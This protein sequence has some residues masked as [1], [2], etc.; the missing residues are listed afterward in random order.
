MRIAK[1]L[2]ALSGGLIAIGCAMLAV[3]AVLAPNSSGQRSAFS[4]G[5]VLAGLVLIAVAFVCIIL[6]F[7]FRAAEIRAFERIAETLREKL[8]QWDYEIHVARLNDLGKVYDYALESLGA[9]VVD[10]NRMQAWVKRNPRIFQMVIPRGQSGIRGIYSLL[11]LNES[12]RR[13]MEDDLLNAQG[14]VPQHIATNSKLAKCFYIGA[15]A[16]NTKLAQGI[17]LQGLKSEIEIV[18]KDQ[19]VYTRP[20]TAAGMRICQK[21][22]FEPL[23]LAGLGKLYYVDLP[24][25]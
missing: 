25:P 24:I 9:G 11:P 21:W 3:S 13:L 4:S 18:A 23:R 17:A 7:V 8:G 12:A 1:R 2:W 20:V 14:V 5:L 6:A 22:G 16:G 10:V 19:R 15:I